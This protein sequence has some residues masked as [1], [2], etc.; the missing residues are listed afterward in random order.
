MAIIKQIAELTRRSGQISNT[1]ATTL[2]C[3]IRDIAVANGLEMM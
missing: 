2:L 3:C 1:F